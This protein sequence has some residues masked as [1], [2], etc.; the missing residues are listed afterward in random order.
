ML[1]GVD[2]PIHIIM[3]RATSKTMDMFEEFVAMGDAMCC[4]EKLDYVQ[5]LIYLG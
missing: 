4:A 3:D 2:E 1:P 5:Y